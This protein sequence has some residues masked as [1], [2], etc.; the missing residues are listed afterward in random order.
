MVS[1]GL[2]EGLGDG[3]TLA[4]SVPIY[5]FQLEA[6]ASPALRTVTDAI[7]AAFA[8][9]NRTA[10]LRPGELANDAF[11]A[12][13]RAGFEAGDQHLLAADASAELGGIVSS[14]LAKIKRTIKEF[15]QVLVG[16]DAAQDLAE[17]RDLALFAWAAVHD[18]C[19]SL[20]SIT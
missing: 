18:Q 5:R 7:L 15:A 13:Q 9:F 4:W 16:P 20:L 2:G 14:W 12:E 6:S 3:L 1:H 19:D 11:F 10:S 8:E 17:R